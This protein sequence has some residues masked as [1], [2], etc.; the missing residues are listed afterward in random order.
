[1]TLLIIIKNMRDF[2]F[3]SKNDTINFNGQMSLEV[4][5]YFND[6]TNRMVRHHVTTTIATYKIADIVYSEGHIV[7]GTV[8]VYPLE[9]SNIRIVFNIRNGDITSYTIDIDYWNTMGQLVNAIRLE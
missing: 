6:Y 3:L 7:A 9:A 2:K 8:H 5:Q 4:I 1:M